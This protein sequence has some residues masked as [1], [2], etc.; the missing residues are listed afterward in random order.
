MEHSHE[1]YIE[2]QPEEGI[3][4]QQ[5]EYVCYNM[6]TTKARPFFFNMYVNENVWEQ[7]VAAVVQKKR[8][9]EWK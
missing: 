9:N 5:V 6:S 8:T 1:K 3:T 7:D 4:A 2:K